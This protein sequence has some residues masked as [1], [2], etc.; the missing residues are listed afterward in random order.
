MCQEEEGIC[1]M[2]GISRRG[3][4]IGVGDTGNRTLQSKLPKKRTKANND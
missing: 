1:S 2:E 4:I 3:E